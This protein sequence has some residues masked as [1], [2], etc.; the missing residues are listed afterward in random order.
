MRRFEV[1]DHSMEPTLRPGDYLVA[2]A[3][4]PA[5]RGD[6]VVFEH[7]PGFHLVKRVAATPGDTVRA[8]GDRLIVPDRDPVPIPPQAVEEWL[9]GDG[10]VFVLSDSPLRTRADSRTFGPIDAAGCLRVVFRYWPV[11]RIRRFR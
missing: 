10:A 4:R 2:T 6:I 9:V 5:R 3:A 1:A 7:G 11:R 8:E